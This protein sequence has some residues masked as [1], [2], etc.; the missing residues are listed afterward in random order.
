[1]EQ[2]AQRELRLANPEWTVRELMAHV[3]KA[4]TS[5]GPAL[6]FGKVQS[7]KVASR[8]SIV[9][10]TTGSS[11]TS[12]EVGL[13][14]SAV[15]TSAKASNTY[16]GAADGDTWSLLLPVTHIAAINVLV[17]AQLLGT[18]PIDLRGERSEYPT[19]D[20]TAIVPA[21]L[22][23][24]LNSDSALLRH[25][26]E[27]KSVL[28]GGA[29]LSETLRTQGEAAGINIVTS[30]G[31]TETCGG[32]VYDGTPLDGVDVSITAENRIAIKGAVLADTYIGAQAQWDAASKDGWFVSSDLGKIEGGKLIVDGRS[33]DVIISGGEN[34]SLG[35]IEKSLHAHFPQLICAAFA[36][37]DLQWGDSLHLAVV[38][39]GLSAE[40]DINSYLA[41]EFGS[42]A[43]VKGFLYLSELPLMG[44]GK[45]N[46][47]KLVELSMEASD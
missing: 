26:K 38:G 1:M 31:M 10:G 34:I 9:V 23:T 5:D 19:V 37:Q 18:N 44:I 17:R 2:N 16:L 22:F 8:V 30:Y 39:D 21:Q 32:C 6:A 36:L 47:T 11:G 45:V 42:F 27:A 43:K 13:S 25:L 29:A 4:L 24:A 15:I 12:K 14:A 20:F 33:D 7:A 40:A 35:Q 46:R 41:T 28:I 3:S